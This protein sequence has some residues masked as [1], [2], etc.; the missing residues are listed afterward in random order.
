MAMFERLLI[1]QPLGWLE[2]ILPFVY[3]IEHPKQ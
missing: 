2:A 3:E 1:E